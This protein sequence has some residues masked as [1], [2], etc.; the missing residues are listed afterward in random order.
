[1]KSH[2]HNS[3]KSFPVTIQQHQGADL[4]WSDKAETK[5]KKKHFWISH[6]VWQSAESHR[7][8]TQQAGVTEGLLNNSILKCASLSL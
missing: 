7:S 4:Q 8:V 5:S 1:M 3:K 2:A 6:G